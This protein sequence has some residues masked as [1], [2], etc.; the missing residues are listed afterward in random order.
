MI[1]KP[2]IPMKIKSR[3]S[4][5]GLHILLHILI[6]SYNNDV[7]EAR[8]GWVEAVSRPLGSRLDVR[9]RFITFKKERIKRK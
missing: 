6:S 2:M 3:M 1:W 7:R 9:H 8:F 5:R 4:R